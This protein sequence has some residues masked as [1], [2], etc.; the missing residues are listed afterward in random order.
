M[1]ILQS[2]Q[3]GL[4]TLEYLEQQPEPVRL[5]DVAAALGVDKSN[6]SHLLRTLVAAG[7]AVQD[8]SRRYRVAHHR[9]PGSGHT[10]EEVV[11]CKEHWQPAIRAIA[12]ETRECV[13]FAV[14]VESR[15]WY[16]DKVESS[17][18]LKVDHPVGALAPLHCTAL[19]KTFIAFGGGEP[20][21]PLQAFTPATRTCPEALRRDIERTRARGY[22]IDDEE[23]AVG[24]RCVGGPIRDAA[25]RLIAA[26]SVSGP[27]VRFTDARLEEVAEIVLGRVRAHAAG[28]AA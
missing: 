19:G 15:I 18:P 13:H 27:A 8:A 25:G 21:P 28:E 16:L 4:R 7:F 3:R 1:R 10:L 5:T 12:R 17:L 6:A 14:R 9:R 11:A 22:A 20:P 24:I 23:F 26:V 2:L